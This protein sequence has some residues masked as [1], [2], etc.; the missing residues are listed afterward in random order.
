LIS[1]RPLKIIH[2]YVDY[3]EN[4]RNIVFAIIQQFGS[5][6]LF[7]TI[8]SS[9]HLWDPLCHELQEIR[10]KHLD[11]PK[12]SISLDIIDSLIMK[13]IVQFSLSLS[14]SLSLSHTHTHTH[15]HNTTTWLQ[16]NSTW[17]D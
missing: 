1:Y 3:L 6:T 12:D 7:V 8:T 5:P 13:H 2:I 10:D 16:K 9:K 14:L 4:M 17:P 15:T 11:K